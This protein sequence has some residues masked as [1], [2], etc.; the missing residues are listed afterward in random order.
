M[1]DAGHGPV[2]AG[3]AIVLLLMHAPDADGRR[4]MPQYLLALA[5]AIALGGLTEWLQQFLPNRNVSGVDVLHDALGA[6]VGLAAVAL[7]EGRKPQVQVVLAAVIVVSSVALAWEPVQC[8]RAYIDRTRAFPTL[9]PL[10]PVGTS[11]FLVAHRSELAFAEIP[12][13]WRKGDDGPALALSF[14]QG[15]RPGLE[16]REPPPD[17]RDYRRLNL[18]LVNPGEGELRFILRILDAEHDWTH[19]DRFNEP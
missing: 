10:P 14:E 18:D 2:F 9:V 8:L 5:V 3:I 16:W 4:R 1:Q 17:W 19:E 12:D 13:P 7:T 11:A 6:V 15:G